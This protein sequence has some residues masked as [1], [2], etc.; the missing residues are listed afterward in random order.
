MARR[1]SWTVS[2]QYYVRASPKK[3]FKAITNPERITRWLADR[4]ELSP[5]KGGR[6]TLGW[7]DGPTHTG[8]LLEFSRGKSITFAWSWEGFE[9]VGPTKFRL[10]ITPQGKG[11]IVTVTHSGIPRDDRWLDLYVG[12]VWGWTYFLMNLKSVVEHGNDLRSKFDG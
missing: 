7:K 11:T 2:N 9:A 3:V 5:R 12:A 8:K 1:K 10:S 4:A 6:Y